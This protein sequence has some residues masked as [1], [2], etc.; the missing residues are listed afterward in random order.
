MKEICHVSVR[1]SDRFDRVA[2]QVPSV[3]CVK[4]ENLISE[5]RARPPTTGGIISPTG[6]ISTTGFSNLRD[7]KATN[8]AYGYSLK[9]AVANLR[10]TR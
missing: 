9:N 3:G 10:R 1:V 2:L 4:R 7:P 5:R 6:A 8:P